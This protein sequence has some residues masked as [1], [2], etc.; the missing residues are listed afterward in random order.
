MFGYEN[1]SW[2]QFGE[3]CLVLFLVVVCCCVLWALWLFGEAGLDAWKEHR[4]KIRKREIL[5]VVRP[6][7]VELEEKVGKHYDEF[8]LDKR[9][10]FSEISA[11]FD[12]RTSISYRLD[13]HKTEIYKQGKAISSVSTQNGETERILFGEARNT[14][15]L[16][17]ACREFS[18][19]LER[20]LL[21]AAVNHLCDLKEAETIQETEEVQEEPLHIDCH[22]LVCVECG[23]VWTTDS[24]GC[25][26]G[27]D[28]RLR[29]YP[30]QIRD[31][32]KMFKSMKLQRESE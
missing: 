32:G 6:W 24:S 2:S 4:R 21:G 13:R 7:F 16:E 17:A 15:V 27:P 31:L 28:D 29:F 19:P 11:A 3:S 8:S 22:Y 9:T 14:K 23:A 10:L 20:G 1:L 26:S 5:E 18:V 30:D 12:A 25:I